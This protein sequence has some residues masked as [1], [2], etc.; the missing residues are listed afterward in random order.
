MVGCLPLAIG[1]Y[2]TGLFEFETMFLPA[3][4]AIVTGLLG[5]QMG[6]SLRGRIQPAVF[7]KLVLVIF[8]IMGFRMLLLPFFA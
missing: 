2:I 6:A 8:M 4:T 5:F 3:I 7:K 1:Y